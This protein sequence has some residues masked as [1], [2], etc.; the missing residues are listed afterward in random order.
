MI[1]SIIWLSSPVFGVFLALE[2]LVFLLSAEALPVVLPLPEL[3]LLEGFSKDGFVGSLGS[4][5][6][7]FSHC[8]V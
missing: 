3:P 1:H 2:D 5:V 7:F 4:D 8:A 6:S